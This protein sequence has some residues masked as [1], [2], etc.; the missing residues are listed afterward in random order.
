MIEQNSTEN[1]QALIRPAV[2]MQEGAGAQ[3]KRL[4]PLSG[5]MNFDPFVLFDDFSIAPGSGF[6]EHPHRGFEAITYLFEGSIEHKDNL[7]NHST[8]GAG[9]A[10]RFTAGSGLVHSEM[11]ADKGLSRGIQLWINLPQRLKALPPSYQQ[12]D[13]KQIPE[14]RFNGGVRRIIVGQDSPV[15]LNTETRYEEIKLDAGA[16]LSEN[17]DPGYRGFIYLVTGEISANGHTLRSGE[18][19]YLD[20]VEK[21]STRATKPSHFMLCLGRAHGEPIRQRGPFVD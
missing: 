18:A 11:P 8:V 9:G 21:L 1:R 12:V 15:T 10:Q 6:P 7:G 16:Q 4:F 17:I 20:E 19:Y 5:W 13:S 2:A 3:V 14:Q